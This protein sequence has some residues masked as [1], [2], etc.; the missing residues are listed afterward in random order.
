MA[1]FYLADGSNR[2]GPFSPE[3][4]PAQGLTAETLV[5]REGMADW[6]PAS[7]IP[8]LRMFLPAAPM[9]PAPPPPA[10]PG[11]GQPQYAPPP[12]SNFAQ[13]MQYAG[14][15]MNQEPGAGLGIASMVLGIVSLLGVLAWCVVWPTGILAIIFG[16]IGVKRVQGKGMA[17]AGLVCGSI[18]IGLWLI[19]IL[20][21][22]A[23]LSVR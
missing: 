14:A 1:Q 15:Y 7:Q 9:P 3:Q 20:V 2:R 17:V 5:W 19:L 16:A 22:V 18:S 8:E 23:V 13:P 12:P 11:Y 21:G 6:L 4:L 10:H